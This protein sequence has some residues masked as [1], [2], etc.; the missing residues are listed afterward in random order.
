LLAARDT[1][2]GWRDAWGCR[3]SV[4][5][6][7]RPAWRGRS[8]RCP[9][10]RRRALR[11]AARGVPFGAE[12][13]DEERGEPVLARSAVRAAA[14]ADR[15][16]PGAAG[17]ALGRALAAPEGGPAASPSWRRPSSHAGSQAAPVDHLCC[18]SSAAR[19]RAGEIL[20]EP[21]KR[22]G[23]WRARR[24]AGPQS[25]AAGSWSGGRSAG[26]MGCSGLSG[27]GWHLLA[28][29][30]ET[31]LP[32]LLVLELPSTRNSS[33]EEQNTRF[34]HQTRPEGPAARG[35]DGV[36]IVRLQAPAPVFSM[37]FRCIA[38]C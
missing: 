36:A 17:G 24:G 12:A 10:H 26:G 33:A 37:T 15:V 3:S 11:R 16:V 13:F 14:V 27:I 18:G 4:S 34:S 25:A 35:I 1:E 20:P 38:I 29:E 21:A 2:G 5:R 22:R 7:A 8:W 31:S 28:L 32:P 30:R 9:R 19:R 6:T 23:I